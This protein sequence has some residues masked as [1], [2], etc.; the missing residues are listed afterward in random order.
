MHVEVLQRARHNGNQELRFRPATA[1]A[2]QNA[3]TSE[4]MSRDVVAIG[5]RDERE[6]VAAEM[7]FIGRMIRT[8]RFKYVRYRGDPVEQLF[9]M[10]KDPWE[11]HN[12]FDRPR[13]ADVLAAHRKL[14]DDWEKRMEVVKP[15]PVV[16][17]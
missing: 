12:L 17:G 11:M 5:R 8:R 16:G 15:T 4:M 14:L 3:P 10:E 1:G 13:Y 6:F 9:D 2:K 7:Q